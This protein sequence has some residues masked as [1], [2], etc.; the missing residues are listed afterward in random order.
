MSKKPNLVVAAV[1]DKSQ[2]TSWISGNKNFDLMLIYY[3]DDP[4]NENK[5]RSE[6]DF[7]IKEKN[8]SKW[9]LIY[10]AFINNIDLFSKYEYIW[11]PDDDCYLQCQDVNTMFSIMKKYNLW[12]AQPSVI[13][14]INVPWSAHIPKIF[15]R[16]T[17]MVEPMAPF[18]DMHTFFRLSE[19]FNGS[20]VLSFAEALWSAILN[21]PKDKV[22]IVDVIKMSHTRPGGVNYDRYGA[23]DDHEEAREMLASF[24]RP[25][26]TWNGK[27][28]SE[29]MD[30]WEHITFRVIS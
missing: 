9:K 17:N 12:L 21:N 1:G 13:D 11:A 28:L 30:N 7:F 24:D 15:L 2:H 26:L 4:E 20:R 25:H 22:A 6:S 14:N 8:V 16:Y 5:Y 23:I 10:S 29:A 18:F 19:T 3:G 27:R